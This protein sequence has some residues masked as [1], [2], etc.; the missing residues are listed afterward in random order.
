MP[1][2]A[3]GNITI[4]IGT[5]NFTEN[6]TE[7]KA[8]INLTGM[9]PGVYNSTIVYS[10]DENHNNVSFNA[11]LHIN[12]YVT[13]ISV[14][15]QDAVVGGKA[16]ITVTVPKGVLNNVTIEIDG[17]KYN[18]TVNPTT[19]VAVFEIYNLTAGNK[20]VTAIYGGDTWYEANAS[21]DQFEVSKLSSFVNVTTKDIN[22]GEVA[23]INVTGPK[24]F[25]GTAKVTINGT[26]YSVELINGVGHVN[27]TKLGNGTYHIYV[28]YVE[29]DKYL[30][31]SNNTEVLIVSKLGK[32][33]FTFNATVAN[34][35]VGQPAVVN[36]TLPADATG[37]VTVKIGNI[38]K[39]FGI[40]GGNNSFIVIGVPVGE[41]NVTVIYNG[42]EKYDRV[43]VTGKIKVSPVN[44][45][46]GNFI[47]QDLGNGTVIV[48][49]PQNATGNITIK[50]GTNNF[51]ENI[52][53]GKAVINLTG[54]VP[55]VYNSTIVYSGDENH[56]NVSFNAT[57]HINK[58][59]TP[60]SVV[61][62]DAVVGGKAI[63]TVTVPKG[64]L[65]NVTIEIDGKK[66]NMTV[67]P[68]TGV[69][70]FE[71]YNLTA[72]NKT[73]TAIYGGDTW[74]EANASTDQFEVSKLSSFVNVTTKDI[75]VGET[76]RVNITG[77]RDFNGTAV[78]I[79]NGVSYS[80][81]LTDGFGF[82]DVDMLTN[83]S[84][85]IHVTYTENDK[86]LASYNNTVRLNVTKW[87]KDSFTFK[88]RVVTNITVGEPAMIII[89]LPSNAT[90]NVTIRVAGMNKTVAVMGGENEVIFLNIPVGV[91]D[92]NAT[93]NGNEMYS[94]SNAS[95]KI[96][97]STATPKDGFTVTDLGNRT[98]VVT[99]PDNATGNITVTIGNNVYNATVKN[100]T[101]YVDMMNETPG[102]KL[103][104]VFYSGDATHG[105]ITV[106]KL[107]SIPKYLTP[108]QISVASIEV[109]GVAYVDV[110]LPENVTKNIIIK[111]DGRTVSYALTNGHAMVP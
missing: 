111:I 81:N 65:N 51:T 78:V 74:Y 21:T 94:P 45:T 61:G 36:V 37:N 10:G 89:E 33:S 19:G 59:V 58:Y 47:V 9:V 42:N 84:Y 66:Y 76:A 11:T 105:N 108:I 15:G 30:S 82:V 97:V 110:T 68:T 6:I 8:V 67:N 60:I 35:T 48:Y 70:V 79:I 12:K 7:G 26:T 4:K 99:V 109:G 91:Y 40:T 63:I 75:K 17:K 39:T 44:T 64:V 50:I 18:M 3:T 62:Q 2:N 101:A 23:R 25:N 106:P 28:T 57:L 38:T 1:Q 43:N 85:P 103:A 93:Y 56:N 31:S 96:N 32:G 54:M 52:T 92:V 86:Y 80:V 71:I 13:P 34:I 49:V 69:A 100:G 29:N 53:E 90:G 46:E 72:G 24:D 73:V 98:L 20:T 88:V 14:V 77:P 55:G 16:I 87:D 104:S 102:W 5:N 41:H 107:V 95:D 83:G 22:V 27:V